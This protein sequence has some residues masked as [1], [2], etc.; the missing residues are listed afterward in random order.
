MENTPTYGNGKLCPV[1]PRDT[2]YSFVT[3]STLVIPAEYITE[4]LFGNE[5][6]YKTFLYIGFP[7]IHVPIFTSLVVLYLPEV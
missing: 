6:I 5:A 7:F 4:A 1:C 2:P 3:I